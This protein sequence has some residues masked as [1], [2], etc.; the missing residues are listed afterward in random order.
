MLQ[1]LTS[2]LGIYGVIALVLF[3]SGVASGHSWTKKY[4]KA[5][6]IAALE[7]RIAHNKKVIEYQTK[8]VTEVLEREKKL[9]VLVEELSDEASKDPTANRPSISLD[10]V[11]RLNKVR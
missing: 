10:G 9:E 5:K 4:Y 6:E 11:R 2:K 1:I 7:E 8:Y 3:G